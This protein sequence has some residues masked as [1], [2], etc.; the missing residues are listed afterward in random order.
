[1]LDEKQK[2]QITKNLTSL[3]LSE[4]ES[5]VYL[6]LI[7]LGEVG[8]S[9]IIK[10]AGL[11][12][13]YVYDALNK[14]EKKGLIQHVIKRGRKK[15]MAKSPNVLVN[16]IA[17]QQLL[18]EETAKTIQSLALIP[19]EQK[20][21]I[22]VGSESY[23]INEFALINRAPEGCQL[24]VIGGQGDHFA[25]EMG[26]DIEKYEKIRVQKKILV[27]YLGSQEQSQEL[28]NSKK[29]RKYFE[30]KILPGLFTGLVNTNIWPEILN[31]NIYGEPVTSFVVYNKEIADSY[32]QFFEVLWKMA[33]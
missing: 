21:E 29:T 22:F 20:S 28:E 30:Y 19:E 17:R 10:K 23:T 8:S 33:K 32:R 27:R 15:F 11:H 6:A 3:G 13:Q 24:L 1:M 5:L 9:K 7:E 25:E 18:A 31:F 4:K 14:L 16:L 26:K 2:S 12:G